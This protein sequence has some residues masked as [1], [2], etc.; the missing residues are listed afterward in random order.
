MGGH[1]IGACPDGQAILE[2]VKFESFNGFGAVEKL[3][4]GEP[5]PQG[6]HGLRHRARPRKVEVTLDDLPNLEDIL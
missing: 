2:L 5:A 3:L 4:Q 6:S 1:I